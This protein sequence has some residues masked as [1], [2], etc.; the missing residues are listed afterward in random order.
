MGIPRYLE[1]HNAVRAKIDSGEWGEKHRLP[2]ERELAEQFGVSRM[3]LRQAIA[4]LVDEGLLERRVGSGT[5]V[6]KKRVN[7]QALGLTS[8]TDL[9]HAAGKQPSSRVISF[10]LQASSSSE[11][12]R[13]QLDDDELVL[14]M[15]R[16]RFG[17]QEPILLEQTTLPVSFV[18]PF[19]K[20]QLTESL[21]QTLSDAGVVFGR[22]TQEITAAAA[23]ERLAD[24][25]QVKEQAP[26][27]AVRQVSYTADGEPFEYVR[28]YYVGE[29]FAFT[30]ERQ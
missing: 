13:L 18:E 26:L 25:L 2:P 10:R 7:E 28:S 11:R 16:L 15:E 14:V 21:W 5:Y 4:T 29:R 17:D 27:L 19:S 12:Q 3:T 30:I 23:N 22:A 9:M 1:I 24:L 8:F 6:S 20:S